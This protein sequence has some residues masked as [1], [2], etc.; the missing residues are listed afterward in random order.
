MHGCL[1]SRIVSLCQKSSPWSQGKRKRRKNPYEERTVIFII[2]SYKNTWKKRNLE[3]NQLYYSCTDAPKVWRHS[4]FYVNPARR[5]RI[6]SRE[7]GA[8]APPRASPLMVLIHGLLSSPS[9]IYT[10]NHQQP[11]TTI[12]RHR[13]SPEF[14]SHRLL[15]RSSGQPRTLF[16][17][18]CMYVCMYV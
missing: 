16:M 9:S 6:W 2:I 15:V 13:A 10:I 8:V 4:Y 1:I 3:R 5:L 18:V 7:A 14:I 12:N 17:Y 11:S